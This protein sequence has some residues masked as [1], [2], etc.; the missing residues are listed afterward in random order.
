MSQEAFRNRFPF[1]GEKNPHFL[2][3]QFR[4]TCLGI[5]RDHGEEIDFPGHTSDIQING[6]QVSPI[7]RGF[8]R[9]VATN[10]GETE[11]I[12]IGIIDLGGG[13]VALDI[14]DIDQRVLVLTDS[15]IETWVG[16]GYEKI[17]LEGDGVSKMIG[18][19]N[20]ALT[21]LVDALNIEEKIRQKGSTSL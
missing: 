11:P 9:F 12:K 7:V 17:D 19:L 18:S 8:G 10:N 4:Q 20:I 21:L 3:D 15:G 14:P 1:P 2:V 6:T 13:N 16:E 5:V